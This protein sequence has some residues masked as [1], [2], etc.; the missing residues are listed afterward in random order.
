MKYLFLVIFLCVNII[1]DKKVETG[2]IYCA[3]VLP[4]KMT[5]AEKKNRFYHLLVPAINKVHAELMNEYKSVGEDIKNGTNSQKI[6]KLKSFYKVK[7]DE[8]LLCALKPHPKSI[9][10]AQAA[11]ESAWGTSRFFCEA[12]NVF[13]MWSTNKNEK[14]IAAKLKREGNRTIWL[15]KFDTIEDSVRAY[16][17]LMARGKA[18][19]EFRKS[20]YV[21]SNVHDIVKKLDKYSEIGPLYAQQLSKMIRYNKLTRYDYE[22][23]YNSVDITA[24]K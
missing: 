12:N 13:G 10:I 11:L 19:K 5:V 17:R 23:A 4:G 18:F 7:S 3:Q 9:V 20:R 8:A 22:I 1:A 24:S 6:A 2:T 16:Y 15:K 21:S 14:R